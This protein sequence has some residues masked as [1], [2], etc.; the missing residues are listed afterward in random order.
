MIDRKQLRVTVRKVIDELN[1]LGYSLPDSLKR[2]DKREPGRDLK[3]SIEDR[4]QMII[5]RYFKRQQA[6]IMERLEMSF[7][8]RKDRILPPIP[9]DD[10]IDGEND[11][12][13]MADIVKVIGLATTSGVNLF[14]EAITIG[15]DYTLINDKALDFARTYAYDLINKNKGGIDA[16]TR[17]SVSNAIQRFIDTPGQTLG[18]TMN[19]LSSSFSLER[20]RM[21]AV[22]ETTRAFAEG[23]KIAG[24]EMKEK[25]PD[26]KVV[27]TWET[28]ND[29]RVCDICGPLQG[30][31]VEIDEPFSSG[32]DKPPAHINC[33][34]WHLVSTKI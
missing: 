15:L 21:I 7:P 34:C 20:A 13:F 9:I 19:Q 2:R 30:E 25:F 33:R 6:R 8:N 3:E 28:N 10:I 17:D 18:D 26:V 12:E 14:K 29:D 24:L 31:E 23:N 4:L 1:D 16:T 27:K 11:D 32:D 5:R 22:T